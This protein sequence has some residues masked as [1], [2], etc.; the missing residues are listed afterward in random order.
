MEP[1]ATAYGMSMNSPGSTSVFPTLDFISNWKVT[2]ILW[3]RLLERRK[4][5]GSEE[6]PGSINAAKG[7]G[8]TTEGK[9]LQVTLSFPFLLCLTVS[10]C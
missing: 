9:E 8:E 4:G 1:C 10:V 5:E 6:E 3:P 2:R 7:L